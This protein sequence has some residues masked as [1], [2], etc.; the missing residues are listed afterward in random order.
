MKKIFVTILLVL[1]VACTSVALFACNDN[2]DEE[3]PFVA[4]SFDFTLPSDIEEYGLSI[5]WFDSDGNPTTFQKNK[6]TAIVIGGQTEYNIKDGINLDA[7]N[8]TASVISGSITLQKTSYLW[9]RQGFNIG[10]FH[11][12]NFADDT[13]DNIV[14]KIFNSSSMTYINKDGA[15]ITTAPDF[16]LTEALISALLKVGSSDD[17]AW[18]NGKNIQELRF[19]GNGVGAVLALSAGEYLDYLYENGAV[20]VGYVPDRIDLIDPYFSNTG[21]ATVVDYYAQ[22]TIGS[23]L[24]VSSKSV[25]ELATKGT[26]FTLVESDKEYYDSYENRYSGVSVIDNTVTLT[27][28]GDALL[29]KNIKKNVAYL[30][31]SET[32]SEKLPEA[33]RK[34]DRSTLDWFLY[35]VN[36]S[37][38]R[39]NVSSFVSETDIRPMLDGLGKLG[40]SIPTSVKYAVSAWTSTVYLR[41]VRGHEY[42]MAK[43]SSSTKA[44]TSYTMERFQAESFQMSDL[45]LDN[46]YAV[47]GYVYL[48]GD[49]SYFVNLNRDARL[50]GIEVNI[51][52]TLDDKTTE[53]QVKTDKDG[54]YYYNLGPNMIGANV[55]ITVN[56]PSR[57][58]T[59]TQTDGTSSSNFKYINKSIISSANGISTTLSSTTTQNFFLYFCSCGLTKR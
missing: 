46:A 10:V 40:T 54:F 31:F 53:A 29:Y 58:Y 11:Y 49:D 4:P 39:T 45:T 23:A 57:N 38:D 33:Y 50:E 28:S 51:S 34:L 20:G 21:S 16:N 17:L 27:D 22:T 25:V 37:D 59:Y 8:Y 12:E 6:P 41:A 30:N 26:V 36:G 48:K 55:A 5:E 14:K 52:M 7:T 44:S 42:K 56:T 15:T 1:C 2:T 13:N 35:T 32:F 9:N 18:S 47:C 43:Y 24:A 3:T 19:I